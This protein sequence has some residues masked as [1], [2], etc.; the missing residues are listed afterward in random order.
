MTTSQG[1]PLHLDEY[2]SEGPILLIGGY[3]IGNYGDE[4]ILAGLLA[5]LPEGAYEPIVVSHDPSETSILHKVKSIYPRQIRTS[6]ISVKSI[7]I[8]GGIF[9]GNMGLLGRLV[10]FFN[11]IT[12]KLKISILYHGLGV[13]PSTPFYIR[14][15]LKASMN[16]ASLITV[17][18][19]LSART[20]SGMGVREV[21]LIPDL[22]FCLDPAPRKRA[23][24]ILESEGLDTSKKTI[25]VS[26][27]RVNPLLSEKVT[28]TIREIIDQLGG[29]WEVLMLP[30]GRHKKLPWRN[31]LLYSKLVA[32]DLPDVK[33]PQ[34]TTR[35]PSDIL[36]IFGVLSTSICMRLHSMIFAWRMGADMIPIPYDDKCASFLQETNI[37]AASLRSWEILKHITG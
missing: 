32:K 31:D 12:Q 8:S 22:S 9:S 7:V 37:P 13:Y 15:F 19:R 24:E 26:I 17:R 21:R 35:H 1:R 18:D 27:T 5:N 11:L 6:L 20:L 30:F 2:L 25:G 3:G 16:T 10:P 33:F 14:P 28:C 23:L 29:D 34:T 4:A 36:S